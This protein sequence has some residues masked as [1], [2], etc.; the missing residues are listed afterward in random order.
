MNFIHE[1]SESK[2]SRRAEFYLQENKPTDSSGDPVLLAEIAV[3]RS[4]VETKEGPNKKNYESYITHKELQ[5][6]FACGGKNGENVQE[7]LGKG[8]T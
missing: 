4:P 1:T 5:E 3:K 6:R 2:P 8:G 7:E